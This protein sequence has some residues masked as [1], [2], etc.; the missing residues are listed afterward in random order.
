MLF[1]KRATSPRVKLSEF[2]TVVVCIN[3]VVDWFDLVVDSLN[4]AERD[5]VAVVVVEAVLF[6]GG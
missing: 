2:A 1:A 4:S 6:D 5:V 3:A